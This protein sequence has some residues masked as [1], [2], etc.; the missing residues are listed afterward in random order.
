M[1]SAVIFAVLPALA[2]GCVSI[3]HLPIEENDE[4]RTK[5]A[6]VVNAYNREL[7][8]RLLNG[9]AYSLTVLQGL[10]TAGQLGDEGRD[11][12]ALWEGDIARAYRKIARTT[13][14]RL[15]REVMAYDDELLKRAAAAT[16]Q[17]PSGDTF[18]NPSPSAFFAA[19]TASRWAQAQAVCQSL[20][21][22]PKRWTKLYPRRPIFTF[23]RFDID[24]AR[25]RTM[26]CRSNIR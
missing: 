24:E 1:R 21:S 13:R 7:D 25:L 22:T 23:H 5:V 26:F 20:V 14:R 17:S 11:A 4:R 2:C 8:D 18:G 6:A 3:S 10:E 15:A 9:P 12:S 19:T 16:K